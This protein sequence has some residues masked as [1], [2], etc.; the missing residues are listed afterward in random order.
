MTSVKAAS[1][2]AIAIAALALATAPSF[3]SAV[4]SALA[5]TARLAPTITG[6]RA[7][8]TAL[9]GRA[10]DDQHGTERNWAGYPDLPARLPAAL[11]AG[12]R[13]PT[14]NAAVRN[15]GS[16]GSLNWSGYAV[17]RRGTFGSVQATFFV[18]YLNCAKSPGQ[19]MSSEWAGLDGFVGS[20]QSVEQVGIAADCS[21]TGR[22]SYFAWSEM[23]PFAQISAPISVL[24]GDSVTAQVSYNP[25]S[26]RFRLALSDN[27]RGERFVRYRRCPD[28]HVG[29]KRLRCARNSA[30]V[31]AEAPATGSGKHVVIDHLSDY[32]AISFAY[33]SIVDGAGRHGGLVSAHWAATKIIQLRSSSGPILARPTQVQL[34]IFDSYWLREY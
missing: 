2:T 23:F 11:S 24:A 8:A 5:P 29:G 28:V 33:I 9:A 20:A 18:P 12:Q 22:A 3:P 21:A 19:T 27:T 10:G 25:A 7:M 15:I 32:G 30:E 6:T 1:G 14:A 34:N 16:A 31:I 4:A 17:T 13:T 26:G